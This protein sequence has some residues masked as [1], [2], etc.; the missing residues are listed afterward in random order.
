MWQIF[1]LPCSLYLITFISFVV[2]IFHFAFELF[3]AC[4]VPKG[5]STISPLFIAGIIMYRSNNMCHVTHVD[6]YG[7]TSWCNAANCVQIAKLSSQECEACSQT[8]PT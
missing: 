7:W 5:Y 2:T 3:V 6:S 1:P 8:E 4:S